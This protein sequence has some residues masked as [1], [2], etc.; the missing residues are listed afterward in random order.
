MPLIKRKR[1]SENLE[2]PQ[3]PLM[4]NSNKCEETEQP[5]KRSNAASQMNMAFW[6]LNKVGNPD[7]ARLLLETAIETSDKLNRMTLVISKGSTSTKQ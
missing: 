5:Y 1:K 7:L 2:Q 3:L 6:F 4:E